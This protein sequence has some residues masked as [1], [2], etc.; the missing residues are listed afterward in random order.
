MNEV[1]NNIINLDLHVKHPINWIE[2]WARNPLDGKAVGLMPWQKD[3]INNMY[4]PI[5]GFKKKINWFGWGS[6]KHGKSALAAMLLAYRM[7]HRERELYVSMASTEDQA[8]IIYKSFIELFDTALWF[9]NL[10]VYKNY[11]IHK[12]NK[13]EFRV[14]SSSASSTHG[15][16]PSLLIADELMSYSDK[17]FEQ[18]DTL[19]ASMSLAVNPQRFY[20]S[21][22]PLFSDHKSLELLKECKKEKDWQITEFKAKDPEKWKEK[23]QWRLANPM[24]GIYPQV[25]KNY[26]RDFNQALNDKSKEARFK[27]YNLGLGCSLDDHRWIDPEN[28]QW[29][30]KPEDR[31]KILNDQSI[32][33]CCGWDISLRGSDSTSWVLAGIQEADDN[34]PLLDRKLYLF[35][36]IFYGNIDQKK[37]LIRDKIRLWNVQ[38]KV[39][40][41]N[42]EVI[43]PGPV[44]QSFYDF[45]C[46]YPQVRKDLINVFDPAFSL[47]YRR[48]LSLEGFV[49]KTTTY[50]P[51]FMTNPIRNLQ[52]LAELKGIYILEKSNDAVKWQAGNGYVNELSRNWCMLQRHQKNTQLNVDYWSATLLAVSELLKPRRRAVIGVF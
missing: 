9:Q 39:V 51:K 41:Q 36:K 37:T 38:G 3:L 40:F 24:Y 8:F 26:L 43:E 15:V 10:K 25:K 35:G 45:V 18:L 12:K 52:R 1:M 23:R 28:L 47:P 34:D 11:I 48:E 20:L 27:R 50:S 31:D 42:K 2:R 29:I 7:C 49:S 30:E 32:L 17:N 22:V 6:K 33:W 16:R 13:T 46:Q 14:L 21:N 4:T 44:L 19:E 5:G